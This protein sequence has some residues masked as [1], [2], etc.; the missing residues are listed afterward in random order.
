[1]WSEETPAGHIK[2]TEQKSWG[3]SGADALLSILFIETHRT[4][5][6]APCLVSSFLGDL[7]WLIWLFSLLTEKPLAKDGEHRMEEL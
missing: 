3:T 4:V 5:S 6:H 2:T 1:M 7:H